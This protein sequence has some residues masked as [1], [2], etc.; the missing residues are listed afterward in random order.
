M[1]TLLSVAIATV[2]YLRDTGR[3]ALVESFVSI[4]KSYEPGLRYVASKSE[5]ANWLDR[6]LANTKPTIYE[7][8]FLSTL[9]THELRRIAKNR[10]VHEIHTIRFFKS[11]FDNQP[12]LQQ[13]APMFFR[14][15][16][17]LRRIVLRD[18]EIPQSWM[19]SLCELSSV[20]ELVISGANCNLQPEA[21]VDMPELK[22]LTL[23]HRGI[24]AQRLN[25]IRNLLPGVEVRIMG[26][27]D[28]GWTFELDQVLS[29][30]DPVEFAQM[31]DILDRLQL[32]IK[33]KVPDLDHHYNEPA[34]A[35]QINALE[36][37]LGMPLHKSVRAWLENSNGWSYYVLNEMHD[38]TDIAKDYESRKDLQDYDW[39]TYD[40]DLYHDHFS[41][42]NVIPI[43]PKIGV[44][45]VD[46]SICWLDDGGESGPSRKLKIENLGHYFELIR[47]EIEGSTPEELLDGGF[48]QIYLFPD[49]WWE[50]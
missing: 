9:S 49:F 36:R 28:T 30:H 37:T 29:N 13:D 41:N 4:E 21:L 18:V 1:L 42:P 35:Q 27:F 22:L 26:S 16:R 44:C 3:D 47:I 7:V 48:K 32:A 33:K 17:G 25:E 31:K 20:E 8:D 45:F 43:G 24:D 10:A 19:P 40:F 6:L 50:P 2:T 14:H 5:P 15:W 12:L 46:G 34:T 11:Y 39:R 23:C 38:T